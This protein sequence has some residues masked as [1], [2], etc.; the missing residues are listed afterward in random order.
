VFTQALKGSAAVGVVAGF[1]PVIYARLNGLSL[2]ILVGDISTAPTPTLD[3]SKTANSGLLALLQVGDGVSVKAALDFTV[4]DNSGLLALLQVGDAVPATGSGMLDFSTADN[5][6]LL[7]LFAFGYAPPGAPG[8]LDY[9]D[10][11]NSGLIV[12]IG[13]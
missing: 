11:N 1:R 13:E 5:S 2:P 8:V 9:S 10:M 3:F 6:D 4:S 12:A 7:A